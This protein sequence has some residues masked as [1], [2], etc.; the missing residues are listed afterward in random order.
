[1]E[2]AFEC[3]P[4]K[5]SIYQVSRKHAGKALI[6]G[7]D[8]KTGIRNQGAGIRKI[9]QEKMNKK[10]RDRIFTRSLILFFPDP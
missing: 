2:A 8:Q 7:R 5:K 6:G 9:S 10:I 1:M 3:R 4:T